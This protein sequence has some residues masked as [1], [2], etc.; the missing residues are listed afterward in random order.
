MKCIVE[1]VELIE[2]SSK[3]IT[4]KD[5]QELFQS[6]VIRTRLPVVEASMMVQIPTGKKEKEELDTQEEPTNVPAL[7][8]ISDNLTFDE[9]AALDKLKE[10]YLGIG[11]YLRM[12]SAVGA[13]KKGVPFPKWDFLQSDWEIKSVKVEV[14][15]GAISGIEVEYKNDLISRHGEVIELTSLF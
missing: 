11:K 1:E 3:L 5:H 2:K 6:P 8:S 15:Q 7:Y 10:D 9:T 13:A 4:D 12:S 14:A